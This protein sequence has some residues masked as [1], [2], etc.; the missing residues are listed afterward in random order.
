MTP[1]IE[2]IMIKKE[3]NNVV[4]SEKVYSKEEV[5]KAC[6]E[7][8]NGDELASGVW[9][10]KYA[11]RIKTGE[12]LEL[13][14]TDMHRRMA[15][16][17]GRMEDKYSIHLNGKTSSLS[18]YGQKREKLTEEKIF[19]YFDKFRYIVPQG[20]VM[21]MLGNKNMIGSLS[22]CIVLPEIF[23]SY[24]GIMF[25]DQQLVQLY[26]RRC[27]CGI[28]ISS[29]RPESS[30]TS[31]AAG[32]ST[33]AISFM[34]RFSNTTREVAQNGRRG[35]LMISIDINSIDVEKFITI[36]QDLKK[37]TGANISVKLSDEF[38]LA[39]KNDT[40]YTH[41]WP[42][43]SA[44]PTMTK[45][46][47][48]RDLWNTIIKC[49]HSSAE[50]G[51]I[52]WDR[53]H[54]YS[55]SS[56]YP[57][58]KNVST[59]PCIT[60]DSWILTDN[61]AYQVKD[62]IGTQFNA[63][64]DGK[65]HISTD[66]GF[67]CTG[68][69]KIYEITTNEGLKLKA[70]S[71]HPF[72]K[73]TELTRSHKK[74]EW[75]EVSNLKPGDLINIGNH[76]DFTWI[77]KG[78]KEIGWLIGSL[79][80]DGNICDGVSKLEYWGNEKM[81]LRENAINLIKRNIEY[82]KGFLG[83][84]KENSLEILEKDRTHIDSTYLTKE[85][86]QYGL[87]ENKI[88]G[89]EIEKTSSDFHKGFLSGWFD[90]DGSVMGTQEKGISVRLSSVILSNLQVAQR[91][92]LR[93][94]IVSTI[95]ENRKDAGY[96]YLPDG[97]G[98]KKEYFCQ[99]GHELVIGKENVIV[100]RDI[101]GFFDSEKTNKLNN[102]INSYK[103]TPYRERFAFK[104]KEIKE[105]GEELVYDCTIPSVS[106]FDANGF[107]IH[108]CAEIAMGGNDSC[109]LIAINMFGC[110]KAPF[111][112][113]AEFDYKK[114][115]EV[116]Y[117]AQRINDDLVDL[118]LEA[119]TKILK[120]I[121][122]DPEPDYI[123]EVEKQ[124]WT[125]LY[126]NG[127]NGR[128][129]GLGFTAL[130]DTIAA[131]G[132]KIDS[133]KTLEIVESI[134]KTKCQAEFDS[135]I[136][137]AIER[138]SFTGFDIDIEN[139]SEFVQMLKVELP[140]VYERMM[141]HGRRNVSVSTVAP[142]GTL[143]LLTQTSS[144]IE[145]VYML[146]YKRRRKINA[147]D[148]NI[149]VDFVDAIGDKWQEYVVFHNKFKMWK[150]VTGKS[151]IEES[152]Y[153]GSCAEEIDWL[154]RVKLQAATQKYTT[155]SISSTLNLPEN[156]PVDKVGEIYMKS[157]E[158]GLKGVTVYRSGS[159]SGVLVSNDEKKPTVVIAGENH[160]SKRPKVLD[161]Q[162]L[163]FNNGG[164]KWIGFL[165]IH[166]ERPYEI[167]TGL[168]TDFPLPDYVE[169]GKIKKSKIVNKKGEKVSKYDFTFN[170]KNGEEVSLESL[171]K[172]FVKEYWNYAKIIS[173]V[174]RHKMPLISVIDV[175]ENLS[176]GEDAITTWKSGV[177]RM[178]KKYIKDGAK[179]KDTLCKN[180][181]DPD[182]L[183][184]QEGCLICKSCGVSKCS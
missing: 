22:N 101:V 107:S 40:E 141:K 71:N 175:V 15:K 108:N 64:I 145:P 163:R 96:R 21:S 130:A 34:E 19:G 98:G 153:K 171:N 128:R 113:E 43:N 124:T 88:L 136:D 35:A 27:G 72:K 109:R 95:Y 179:A 73:V 67:Y 167:F 131:L 129:T 66:E 36:K 50:P 121:E 38:M 48:A 23:D 54:W 62:L 92:L 17:F 117:E 68:K 99:A 32:T 147:N 177:I 52:F 165:G 94:G 127:K 9:M 174:L 12:L 53:Q 118:E 44:N 144:G 5:L 77:G 74:T 69:K 154:K 97:K 140:V 18:E 126:E 42:I 51:L 184:F 173:A 63:I 39:V 149:K 10:D 166:E 134:M 8:F 26:K 169:E 28:D 150:D 152:P 133:N 178:L 143:S 57:Q 59:N 148:K 142:C 119:I 159:R 70:T 161:A 61:G 112:K 172:A 105:V 6:L 86:K 75:V 58:Y 135:S 56:I 81:K 76:K 20:S 138:G 16:E 55:T 93:I 157:W 114:F 115:Y 100:F 82:R 160:A 31:N 47:K 2:E 13:T 1:K 103:R 104:I 123:K 151:E 85:A 137:M 49:A 79:L 176:L 110:V 170:D 29:L 111:T 7:Y 14:P 168:V 45:V 87:T 83:N 33:G 65:S 180:C 125:A 30:T 139:K 122:S 41:K 116:T 25:T 132:Y 120:K 3:E 78:N 60:D 4:N 102:L 84:G 183:I 182:G 89:S 91:M 46:I 146:S 162:V 155:H 37:V 158:L 181:G 80:G 24:G 106:E 164:E 90:A 156:T 11:S